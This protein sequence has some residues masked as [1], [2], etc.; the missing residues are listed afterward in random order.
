VSTALDEQFMQQA[1]QLAQ[2][3]AMQNEVPVGAV[4][5]KDQEI[6]GIGWNQPI[7][8]HDPCAH[9]EIVALRNGAKRLENYRLLETT[10]YVTLEP[11]L[12]CL[13]A[14]MHA[15]VERVVFAAPDPKTGALGGAFNM[16]EILPWNH[17]IIIEGGLLA[18]HSTELLQNFFR[19]RRS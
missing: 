15:R 5:I 11:C 12:M 14:I 1:L 3:A 13:G 8:T 19:S 17:R 6:I 2:H 9:A 10:L 18:P 4:L 7:N 16:L